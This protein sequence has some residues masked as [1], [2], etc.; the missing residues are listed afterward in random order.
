[1]SMIKKF[2]FYITYNDVLLHLISGH[3]YEQY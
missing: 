1:M 2:H 3:R